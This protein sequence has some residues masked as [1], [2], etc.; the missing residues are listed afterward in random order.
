MDNASLTYKAT[1]ASGAALPGWLSFDAATRTFSGT[2][3]QNFNGSLDIKVTASDGSLSDSD[4]FTL[5]VTPVNDAPVVAAPIADQRVDRG[6]AVV[7]PGSGRRVHGCRRRQPDLHG[8]A[9]RT[10]RPCRLGSVSTPSTR[11][12]SGTPPQDFNGTVDL[13]VTASD[14]SLE[15]SDTFTL[16]ID[17]V[18]DAPVVRPP[19]AD[20]TIARGHGLDLPDPAERSPMWTMPA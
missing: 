7:V 2:P 13:K 9:W 4:T 14:G 12:F 11:T 10:A 8:H 20:Q 1:L 16:T 17:P 3:P 19:I 6:H 18:N 5:T 15:R